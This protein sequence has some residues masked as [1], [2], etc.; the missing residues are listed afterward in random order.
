MQ[1]ALADV[2]QGDRPPVRAAEV[3][4]SKVAAAGDHQM[5][6]G[7]QTRDGDRG[8]GG[9]VVAVDRDRRCLRAEAGR[10]EADLDIDG[11]TWPITIGNVSTTGATKSRSDEVTEKIVSG[12]CP[13]L[14][15]ISGWSRKSSTH[16]WPK[17]PLFA[18]EET[19]RGAG[20]LPV[21][22]TWCGLL[23]SLLVTVS[24]AAAKPNPLGWKRMG[25]AI[26]SPAS[27]TIG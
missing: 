6:G 1:V 9:R 19:S 24:V 23:G 7:S 17:S 16:T 20:A 4:R 3:H 26:E 13:L 10:L 21:T 15:N 11:V 14:L 27:T 25:S 22:S 5:A 8:G 18:I 2:M 12:Q